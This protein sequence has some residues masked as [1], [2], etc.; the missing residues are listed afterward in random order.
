MVD[1]GAGTGKFTRLLVDTG[2]RLVA[3]EPLDEMRAQLSRVLPEVEAL[4]AD[5]RR[6]AASGR[7]GARG[8]G[9]PGLPLVRRRRAEGDPPPA[10]AGRRAGA[11]LE[12]ARPRRPALRRARGVDAARPPASGTTPTGRNRSTTPSSSGRCSD[13]RFPHR[14]D[15]AI[16]ETIGT[17]SY[18]GAM[19]ERERRAFLGRGAPDLRRLRR[20]LVTTGAGALRDVG[21]PHARALTAACFWIACILCSD[22]AE[23]RAPGRDPPARP[24]ARALDPGRGRRGARRSR[25]R[26]RPDDGLARHRRSS[27]S[28]RSAAPTAGSSTRCPGRADLAG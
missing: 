24:R 6:G 1:L 4:G 25:L 11:A 19:E 21:L 15:E 2:A 13:R 20:R 3:V 10:R 7:L 16:E 23:V 26:R 5:R 18:V 22:A 9:R 27:A 14:V 12:R 8:H 17:I 28:S